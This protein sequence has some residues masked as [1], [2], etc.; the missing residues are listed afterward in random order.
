MGFLA[1]I[2]AALAV[3]LTFGSLW[4]WVLL[5]IAF[6]TITSFV[7]HERGGAAFFAVLVT[8][9]LLMN[10]HIYDFFA[11]IIHRPGGTSVYILAYFALGTIWGIVKWFLHV[12]RELERYN[13]KKADFLKYRGNGATEI[14]P[15]LV[16]DFKDY[17]GYGF[18]KPPQVS[19]HKGDILMWMTYWPFSGI[20]TLIND[21]VRRA[22]RAI[23]RSISTTLQ[24]MSDRLFKSAQAEWN[25]PEPPKAPN[26]DDGTQ[27]ISGARGTSVS[28][29]RY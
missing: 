18:G 16:K 8:T 5:F 22:F 21:P 14:T 9:V 27:S 13:E 29:R 4:F 11:F 15:E 24:A 19:E 23:Y 12:T 17:A 26:V 3:A 6:C 20:W 2:F 10:R 25:Q 1:G 7:E 28:S